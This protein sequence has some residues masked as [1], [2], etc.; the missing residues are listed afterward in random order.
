[1]KVSIAFGSRNHAYALALYLQRHSLLGHLYT[2]YPL[3]MLDPEV[4]QHCRSFP[5]IHTSLAV[6]DRLGFTR[7]TTALDATANRTFDR[8]VSRRMEPSDVFMAMS[9]IGLEARRAAKAMGS[10]TVCD[11]GSTHIRYQDRILG[12]EYDLWGLPYKPIQRP[13]VETEEAEYR[14]ADLVVAQ[15]TFAYRSFVEAGMSPRNVTWLSPGVDVSFFS[16]KPR[17]DNMFRIL[18]LGQMT[19]RKGVQYLLQAMD[20]LKDPGTELV[21]AGPLLPDFG[22]LMARFEGRFRYLGR[23][24]GKTELR[25][26]YNQCSVFVLPSVEDGFGVVIHEAMACGVPVI[27]TTNTGGPDVIED[28]VDGYVV[29]VRSPEAL[30]DRISYMRS[31]HGLA[32]EMGREALKKSKHYSHEAYN[33]RVA[34]L[35]RRMLKSRRESPAQVPE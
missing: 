18:Y 6:A 1:M 20:A 3:S 5:Y 25:E 17:T 7:I 8:W 34:D 12:E 27:A 2:R 26:L 14:E 31:K 4:R 32:A 16:P 28:G 13:V 22:P 10:F 35:Y 29:P 19:L 11:R 30:A 15:S 23:Q 33:S 9:G 21:L 24:P